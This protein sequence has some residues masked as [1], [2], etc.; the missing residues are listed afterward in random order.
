MASIIRNVWRN[1]N[2]EGEENTMAISQPIFYCNGSLS[3]GVL[4]WP[5]M[6]REESDQY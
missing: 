1:I 5:V 2:I 6:W 4:I 3:N